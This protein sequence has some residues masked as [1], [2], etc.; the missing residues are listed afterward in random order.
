MN[1]KELRT[2]TKQRIIIGFIA[3]LLLFST[4]AIY[5]LIVLNGS[6]KASSSTD[7]LSSL[8]TQLSE[9]RAK[10]TEMS[11]ALSAKYYD[12]FSKY[13]ENV[14]SYNATTVDNAG[15]VTKDIAEGTGDQITEDSDY[16]AYYIGWCA[17]ESIF[18]SSFDSST[19][20]TA[21]KEPIEYTHGTSGFIAGWTEGVV[22][23]KIGGVREID[24]PGELAYGDSY[25]ICG[26]K[27]S[28]LK[29]ILMTIDSPSDDYKKLS[30][31]Y[32]QLYLQYYTLYQQQQS[33]SAFQSTSDSSSTSTSDSTDTSSSS[34]TN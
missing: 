17:D 16:Y 28:P 8:E 18:D 5:M 10:L 9:K 4:I 3:F 24:I 29:F 1:E 6:S 31:E 7:E 2:S 22:G 13:R 15:L 30:D 20:P 11:N 26:G 12:T 14:K 19:S 25:E 32:N 21:L 33:K 23:M 27:N 34:S